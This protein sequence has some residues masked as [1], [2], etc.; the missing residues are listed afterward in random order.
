MF[1]PISTLTEKEFFKLI[2][3][4]KGLL[5]SISGSLFD[6]CKTPASL[7]ALLRCEGLY[8]S[9]L[10]TWRRQRNADTLGA[11]EPRKRGPKAKEP[12]PLVIEMGRLRQ[13]NERLQKRLKQAELIIDAQKKI[14]QILGITLETQVQSG[15]D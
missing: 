5:V 6:V 1:I 15:K 2:K 13:E 14:S 11:L 10:A 8:H 9:N 3:V 4:I 12:D 7:G